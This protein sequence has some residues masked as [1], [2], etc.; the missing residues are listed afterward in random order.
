MGFL[1]QLLIKADFKKE[2]AQKMLD[3]KQPHAYE[4]QYFLFDKREKKDYAK[5][6]D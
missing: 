3:S 1:K 5:L 4:R 2:I 6:A